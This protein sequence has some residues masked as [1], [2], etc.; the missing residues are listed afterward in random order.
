MFCVPTVWTSFAE[1]FVWPSAERH[2]VRPLNGLPDAACV[3]RVPLNHGKALML[4]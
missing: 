3:L 4:G 2:D 1:V